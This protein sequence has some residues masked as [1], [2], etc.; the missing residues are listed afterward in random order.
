MPQPKK[1]SSNAERQRAYRQRNQINDFDRLLDWKIANRSTEKQRAKLRDKRKR[2]QKKMDI[3]FIGFD[4]EGVTTDKVVYIKK[5]KPVYEHRYTLLSSSL[6]EY[7]ED[8]NGLT[9]EA[10]LDF[11][12]RHSGMGVGV[13]F[14][15]SYDITMILKDLDVASLKQLWKHG[16]V[17]Y[18]CWW[19]KWIPGKIF[20]VGKVN[21][22]HK[23]EKTIIIYDV[24]AFFQ[25]SFVKSLTDWGFE[26]PAEISAGKENRGTFNKKD[27]EKIRSYNHLECDLLVQLMN[28]LRHAMFSCN[29][30]PGQWHGA[31]AIA[32]MMM[33]AHGTKYE[34]ASP[35]AMIDFFLKAYYGGRNQTLQLGEFDEVYLHDVNS[36]YP[37]AMVELPTAIGEWYECEPAFSEHPYQLY[38]VSW[39]LPKSTVVTPFP[40]RNNSRIFWPLEGRGWYW[41][42]EVAAAIDA[43]GS[44]IKIERCF[45]FQPAHE[46]KPFEFLR[47][48]YERRKELIKTGSDA[49]KCLKLGINA[50]YGKVAQSI[51][52]RDKAPPYQ[53]FFWAGY[54]TSVTR[55]QV[56]RL[57]MRDPRSIVA[58]STDGVVSTKQL[59]PFSTNGK[60]LGCWDVKQVSNYFI[61]QSGVYC[62]DEQ[63]DTRY[64][65]RGFS[66]RSVDYDVLRQLWR[67]YGVLAA[68][69]YTETRFIGLGTGLRT[70][71]RDI[72][73]WQQQEREIVFMPSS[74]EIPRHNLPTGRS[75]RLQAPGTVGVSEPYRMKVDWRE[76]AADFEKMQEEENL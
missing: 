47:M 36:A 70:D 2:I 76:S 63:N 40:V 69:K 31:G 72:G 39:K 59:E 17:Y 68:H 29:F 49:E 71:C 13:G 43:Y 11:L 66:Y 15:F 54:T 12:L 26:V 28:K 23:I 55:S 56:F 19:I 44:K 10:C 35:L 74:M 6:G 60:Q 64:K 46:N 42:P 67:D 52:K 45:A 8:Y 3:P 16:E 33:E 7:I 61:V 25:K 41:Q 22:S 73:T 51:G 58:F 34:N 65:S 50:C 21:E 37:A 62:Y 27:K 24:F 32:S 14:G 5:G 48:Y 30:L 4:G 18:K 53:N 9:T 38:E 20:Q 75:I 57:A 1:H